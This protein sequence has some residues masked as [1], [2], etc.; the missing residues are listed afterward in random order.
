M[1]LADKY[2]NISNLYFFGHLC[3]GFFNGARG[4]ESS[5][6]HATYEYAIIIYCT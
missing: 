4:L 5:I 1:R 2:S 6:M 3:L